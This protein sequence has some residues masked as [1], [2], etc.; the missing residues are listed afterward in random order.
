MVV[1]GTA[2]L[3]AITAVVFLAGV[4][5]VA[6]HLH[7]EVWQDEAVTLLIYAAH[8]PLYPFTHY[9]LPNNHIL[10]SAL[11]AVLHPEG[12]SVFTL[13]LAM[14]AG[15]ALT[16]LL[17]WWTARRT[18][19]AFGACVALAVMAASSVAQDFALQLRGYAFAWSWTLLVYVTASHAATA[20]RLAAWL[21][22]FGAATASV[23]IMPTNIIVNVT[24][25][26]AAW[27]ATWPSAGQPPLWRGAALYVMAGLGL[28]W[29]L[30]LHEQVTR[31]LGTDFSYWTAG[32]LLRHWWAATLLPWAWLAPL[33]A[34]GGWVLHRRPRTL[35]DAVPPGAER[36]VLALIAAVVVVPTTAVVLAP[37]VP[38]PRNLVPLLPLLALAAGGLVGAGLAG[39]PLNVAGRVAALAVLSL[40]VLIGGQWIAPCAGQLRPRAWP[41]DLCQHFY[42]EDY[43]PRATVRRLQDTLRGRTEPVM[44]DDEITWASAYVVRTTP[45]QPAYPLVHFRRWRRLVGVP[46]R[47]VLTHDLDRLATM[48]TLYGYGRPQRVERLWSTGFFVLYEL[49]WNDDV[50]PQGG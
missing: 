44:A 27:L 36:R 49:E 31:L 42:L 21:A 22:L 16:L 34:Y 1:N 12:E 28:A 41:P 48:L 10:F 3:K 25:V 50:E 11:L 14:L 45:V 47:F 13:R 20:G 5:A 7:D 24:A 30:V 17:L 29:Y 23:L 6:P 2:A 8:G 39:L 33:A 26:T 15:W 9:E 46:P 32:G 38:F 19:G 43:A 35:V 40:A 4:V 18:I 37:A